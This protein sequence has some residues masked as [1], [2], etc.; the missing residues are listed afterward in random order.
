MNGAV[1]YKLYYSLQSYFQ[2]LQ[3]DLFLP[4]PHPHSKSKNPRL[5]AAYHVFVV[6][7]ASVKCIAAFVEII[8]LTTTFLLVVRVFA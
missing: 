8:K 4:T 5:W 1:I 2:L 6:S 3:V 7:F